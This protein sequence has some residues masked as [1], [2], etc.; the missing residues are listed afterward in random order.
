MPDRVREFTVTGSV[1]RDGKKPGAPCIRAPAP[2]SGV[3]R[4][5]SRRIPFLSSASHLYVKYGDVGGVMIIICDADVMPRD[6]VG[7]SHGT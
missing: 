3:A 1:L 6:T 2:S 4:L 5:I 7:Q